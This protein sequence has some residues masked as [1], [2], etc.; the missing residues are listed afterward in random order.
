MNG[1]GSDTMP[2]EDAQFEKLL[3]A[4][5]KQGHF[6]AIMCQYSPTREKL[7]KKHNVLMVIDLLASPHVYK[8][9]QPC[10]ELLGKLQSSATVAAYHL[11][12]DRFSK[13]GEG[14]AR[15]IDNVHKWD[16]NH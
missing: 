3:L 13:Q 9:P 10:E 16:P 8:E 6:N 2:K 15:D 1:Y 11:W 5:T 7:C 14:R 4:I 12:S